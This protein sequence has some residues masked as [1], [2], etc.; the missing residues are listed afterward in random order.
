MCEYIFCQI[1]FEIIYSWKIIE[2][3]VTSV[4]ISRKQILKFSFEPK[5]NKNIFVFL[6]YLS[7]MGQIKKQTQMQIIML[8]DK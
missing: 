8:D 2:Y 6:P 7:K 5:T 4:S 3:C 1:W